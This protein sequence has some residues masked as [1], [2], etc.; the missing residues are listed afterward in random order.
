MM[1][2]S[3]FSALALMFVLE[4]LLPYLSPPLWRRAFQTMFMQSDKYIRIMG[5]VSMLLG[6][7]LLY[8]IRSVVGE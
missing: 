4:G 6:V 5:L 8:L 2:N 1:W 3:L 7:A